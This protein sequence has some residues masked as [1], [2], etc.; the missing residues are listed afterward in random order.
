MND[1]LKF[2]Y[3]VL[4]DAKRIKDKKI[5]GIFTTR[6]CTNYSKKIVKDIVLNFADTH[7]FML[8]YETY[9]RLELN[10]ENADF[11]LILDDSGDSPKIK[12]EGLKVY[13]K[14][15]IADMRL[16]YLY[17]DL[18]I[19]NKSDN[20]LILEA[21]KYSKNLNILALYAQGLGKEVFV[22]PGR[23]DSDSSQGTNKLIFDGASPFYSLDLLKI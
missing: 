6:H 14:N 7:C 20:V 17:K 12:S 9:L 3:K 23:I 19:S 16:K 13:L 1:N 11:V 18:F 8:T 22:L 10:F 2:E 5:L 15:E 21:T 4:G